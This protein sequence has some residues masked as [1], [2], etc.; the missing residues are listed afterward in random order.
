MDSCELYMLRYCICYHLS[1]ICNG[2][3]FNLFAP[4]H[5]FAHHYRVFLGNFRSH[6]EEAFQFILIIADIHCC[7]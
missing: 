7:T 5:E 3:K 1:V 6:G 4:L 2:I